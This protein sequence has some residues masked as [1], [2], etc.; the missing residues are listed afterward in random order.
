VI[1]AVPPNFREFFPAT[2]FVNADDGSH[3]TFARPAPGHVRRCFIPR[4]TKERLSWM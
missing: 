2:L 4:C 3:S 1:D